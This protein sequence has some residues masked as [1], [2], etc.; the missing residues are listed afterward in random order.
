[1]SKRLAT[2][3]GKFGDILWSLAAV[4]QL[5]A[6]YNQP[7]DFACMP[8]YASLLPLLSA[9][10]S[11]SSAFVLTEWECTGSPFGDQPWQAPVSN[12]AYDEVFHLTYQRHPAPTPLCLYIAQQAGVQLD[13]NT[14]LDVE[15]PD[16]VTKAQPY[17]AYGWNPGFPEQKGYFLEQVIDACRI[18]GE[19][20]PLWPYNFI[21]ATAYPWAQAAAIIKGAMAFI[22]CRS[23]NYV[24]AHGVGQ[25][26]LCFEPEAWRREITYSYP[27][28]IEVMCMNAETAI[29]QLKVWQR[30]SEE[31]AYA[32]NE[33]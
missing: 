7:L 26:V 1:M 17:I 21:D 4:R 31:E 6:R 9:Q 25:R 33:T 16:W 23:A 15:V 27:Y 2:F 12:L 5:A 14:F 13:G 11:I 29:E 18:G 8:Q 30:K 10:K 3:S 22:G 19:S 20:N 32:V 28:G 24:I